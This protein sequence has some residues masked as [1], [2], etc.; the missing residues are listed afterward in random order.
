MRVLIE[1]QAGLSRRAGIGQYVVHLVRELPAIAREGERFAVFCVNFLGR[2]ASPYRQGS[3][4]DLRSLRC[5]PEK[6]LGFLWKTVRFPPFDRF[7]GEADIYHFPNFVV[8]PLRRGKAIATIHDLSFIRHPECT[9]AK[10]LAFLSKEV[11]RTLDQASAVLAD[12]RFT[13]DEISEVYGCPEERLRVTH[14]GLHPSFRRK[15]PVEV[16]EKREHYGLPSE[17]LLFVSTIEPRKNVRGLLRAYRIAR[18][19]FGPGLP[20]LVIVGGRGWQGEVER[21]KAL[22]ES[23]GLVDRVL[24]PGYIPYEELPWI[25]SGASLFVFP[26]LYEGFGM[27]P[28]E[29]MACGTPVVCSNAASLP[30]VVGEAALRVDP[31]DDEGVADAML[32]A[33]SDSGLRERLVAAGLE[34]AGRFTW[35][36]NAEETLRVYREVYGS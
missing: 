25:Y 28:L 21:V 12:S 27:P 1:G 9:E 11:P 16:R 3:G 5:L 26:S 6:A 8:R 33:L 31:G 35:R 18:E 4:Y 17:Y 24:L 14:L 36:R 13:A 7:A 20:P 15:G 22:R 19:R 32:Q 29:A 2:H 30:E 10:N 34:R 23:L